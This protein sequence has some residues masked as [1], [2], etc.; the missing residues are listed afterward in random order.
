MNKEK[1]RETVTK[2]FVK[3]GFPLSQ[4]REVLIESIVDT[5]WK[6]GLKEAK[7]VSMKSYLRQNIWELSQYITLSEILEYTNK[8]F[9]EIENDEV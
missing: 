2:E 4:S 9:M 1:I 3:E 7:I 6:D 5:I 8:V